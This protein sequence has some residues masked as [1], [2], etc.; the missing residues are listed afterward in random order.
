MHR[1]EDNG[2]TNLNEVECEGV[3]RI[4]VSEDTNWWRAALNTV[5]NQDPLS[6]LK[7]LVVY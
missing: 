3:D 1:W 5:I 4:H 7:L 6:I 2:K